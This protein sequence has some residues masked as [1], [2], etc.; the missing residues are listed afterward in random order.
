VNVNDVAVEMRNLLRNQATQRSVSL[1]VDLTTDPACVTGNRV[2]LRQV[3][4]N[5]MLNGIEPM[6][7]SG[8]RAEHAASCDTG[9]V[10]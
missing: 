1:R 2:Q 4:M 7:E 9:R 6:E 5:L 3:L 10:S 8:R